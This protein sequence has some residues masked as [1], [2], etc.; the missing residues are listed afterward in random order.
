MPVQILFIDNGSPFT[1]ANGDEIT[2]ITSAAPPL[3]LSKPS[4]GLGF[5]CRCF[6][7]LSNG[8]TVGWG[9]NFPNG[10]GNQIVK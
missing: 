1:D 2:V 10:G 4:T 3:P 7:T 8:M 6:V 5:T 9:P